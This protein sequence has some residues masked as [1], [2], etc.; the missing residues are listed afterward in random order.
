MSAAEDVARQKAMASVTHTIVALA[1]AGAALLKGRESYPP[2]AQE[3]VTALR[4]DI[5]RIIGDVE[6]LRDVVQ[7]R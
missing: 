3:L 2:Q 4:E 6:A 1:T 5:T 7:G